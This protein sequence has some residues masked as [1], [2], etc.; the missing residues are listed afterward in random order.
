MTVSPCT[1]RT[2]NILSRPA[3]HD[4]LFLIVIAILSMSS[5]IAG[6]GFYSDDWSLISYM[7]FSADQSLASVFS[8]VSSAWDVEIRPV[9]FFIYAVC[10]KLFGLTALGYHIFNAIFFVS[11]MA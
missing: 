4:C 1:S 11:G 6:L 3:V 2:A 10:Y 8:A 7:K 5:Y 9:Q